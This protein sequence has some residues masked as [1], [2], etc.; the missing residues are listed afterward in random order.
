MQLDF[1][2]Y[3]FGFMATLL[4]LGFF[5]LLLTTLF[6]KKQQKNKAEKL[7]LINEF[8]QSLI[9]AQV[10]TQEQTLTNISQEIHDNV[11]Q[12]LSLAKLK[13]NTINNEN[14][15]TE[16]KEKLSWSSELISKAIGDLRA[17]SKSLNGEMF[18]DIGLYEA[19]NREVQLLQSGGMVDVEFLSSG[20]SFSLPR[21]TEVVIYRIV[22]E[23]IQNILKHARAKK[24]LISLDYKEPEMSL[25]ISDDGI[26]FSE[27]SKTSGA[28]GLGLRN[29]KSRAAYIGADL[30]IISVPQKGTQIHIHCRLK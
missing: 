28:T 26:G 3:L 19:I 2:F 20:K 11:G 12:V 14:L 5:L 15:D 24:I 1:K 13:L 18:V 25:T 22:Q 6:S 17:L 7:K 27:T 9:E 21:Q 16:E 10:Q 4:V 29:M 30:K 23:G 8:Q